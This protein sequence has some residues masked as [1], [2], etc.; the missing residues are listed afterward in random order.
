MIGIKIEEGKKEP[1]KS[2]FL[3]LL[4]L[5]VSIL[6]FQYLW[7]GIFEKKIVF[8]CF[9]KSTIK[10]LDDFDNNADNDGDDRRWAP[11]KTYRS[12]KKCSFFFC[13]IAK[14]IIIVLLEDKKKKKKRT[15]KTST[16]MTIVN[17]EASEDENMADDNQ[18]SEQ[19]KTLSA[20]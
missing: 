1:T 20:D 11:E 10:V 7:I 17:D 2:F 15:L 6:F 4:F 8:F 12:I 16:T 14:I 9:F 13:L 18:W 3:F 19:W 5:A